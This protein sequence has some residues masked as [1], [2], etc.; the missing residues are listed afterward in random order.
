MDLEEDHK[1]LSNLFLDKVFYTALS[2]TIANLESLTSTAINQ[3]LKFK[4]LHIRHAALTLF[5]KDLSHLLLAKPGDLPE[6]EHTITDPVTN[7]DR[8]CKS[9]EETKQS[10]QERTQM[11]MSPPAVLK[12]C[13]FGAVTS[14]SVG[15][16]GFE[17]DN[18]FEI[19]DETMKECNPG[20]SELTDDAKIHV[21]EAYRKMGSLVDETKKHIP[22][23]NYT[24]FYNCSS[25]KFSVDSVAD[26]LYKSISNTPRK[27]RHKGFH[28][29]VIGRLPSIWIDGVLLFIQNVLVSRCPPRNIKVMTRIP[30]PKPDKPGQTRPISLADDMFPFLTD[31]VSKKFSCGVEETGQLGPEITAYRQNKSVTDITVDQRCTIEDAL[32]FGKLL[33]IVK[34]NEEFF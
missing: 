12:Q 4:R 24:F 34:E 33:G 13:L 17:I 15:P 29:A 32:E 19:N 25:G 2:Q 27:S 11:Y 31:Q 23:L 8:T 30:I 20:Y 3:S 6:I 9:I 18:N 21:K 14:D 5:T 22:S 26:D 16:S 28:L 7:L 10:T 1:R